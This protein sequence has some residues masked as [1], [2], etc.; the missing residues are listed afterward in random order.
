MAAGRRTGCCRQTVRTLG[1]AVRRRAAGDA[2]WSRGRNRGGVGGHASGDCDGHR[3]AA[4]FRADR[5]LPRRR[6]KDDHGYDW[7]PRSRELG[8]SRKE[9]SCSQS[10]VHDP[11]TFGDTR[12]TNGCHNRTRGVDFRGCYSLSRDELYLCLSHTRIAKQQPGIHR[13]ITHL[14]LSCPSLRGAVVGTS[15]R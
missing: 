5:R 15:V 10:V 8:A 9:L 11:F 2:A 3:S 7:D 6:V 4:W 13:I 12:P 14:A 1:R